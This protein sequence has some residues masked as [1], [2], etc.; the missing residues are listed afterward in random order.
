MNAWRTGTGISVSGKT[1]RRSAPS[2]LIRR[3]SA[4]YTFEVW[5]WWLG[6]ATSREMLGQ[7]SPA[8]TRVHEPYARPTKYAASSTAAAITRPRCARPRR[9]PGASGP[10][11]ATAARGA[12][13]ASQ[14][15]DQATPLGCKCGHRA[16]DGGG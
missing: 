7:C 16:A 13:L 5:V 15:G 10:K 3:P 8:H 12:W 6:F 11:G 9:Q 14:R 4:A 2:S 1:V